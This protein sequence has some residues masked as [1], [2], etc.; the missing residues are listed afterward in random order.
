MLVKGKTA[1][2]VRLIREAEF[3]EGE[4][5]FTFQMNRGYWSFMIRD[6]IHSANF[7]EAGFESEFK[8]RHIVRCL[9]AGS[10]I[11]LLVDG[12][13]LKPGPGFQI[14]GELNQA[15]TAPVILRFHVAPETT[16][17]ISDMQIKRKQ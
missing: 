11:K 1:A 12:R 17:T 7:Y 6:G 15:L 10:R 4:I 14:E 3:S 2:R 5:S 8:G 9:V 13:E 16:L